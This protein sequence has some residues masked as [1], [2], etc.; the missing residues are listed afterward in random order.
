M[1]ISFFFSRTCLGQCSVGQILSLWVQLETNTYISLK[2]L[3]IALY[4]ESHMQREGVGGVQ[5]F[6]GHLRGV[7]MTQYI[8]DKVR[9]KTS[10]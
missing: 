10:V 7:R 2:I 5:E 8:I 6:A 3:I 1:S 4:L 9:S